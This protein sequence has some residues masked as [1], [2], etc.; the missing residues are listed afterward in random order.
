MKR[1]RSTTYNLVN[2]H[3]HSRLC[4]LHAFYVTKDIDP[5]SL[6]EASLCST[7]VGETSGL[8]VCHLG[9]KQEDICA[10]IS[11]NPIDVVQDAGSNIVGC[12][13]NDKIRIYVNDGGSLQRLSAGFIE[14]VMFISPTKWAFRSR[15]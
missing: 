11:G 15:S 3:E 5:I 2:H 10:R 12:S 6:V 7:A 4:M 1:K 14:Q 9:I 8:W 13:I